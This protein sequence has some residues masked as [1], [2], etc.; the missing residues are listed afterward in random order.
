MP[1]VTTLIIV[2]T[3]TARGLNSFYILVFLWVKI[4]LRFTVV[5]FY[6]KCSVIVD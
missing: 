5:A 2:T 6:Y 3:N 1:M 4:C